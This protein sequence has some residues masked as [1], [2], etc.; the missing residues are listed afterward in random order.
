MIPIQWL[1]EALHPSTSK[2][3]YLFMLK[4]YLDE[5]GHSSDSECRFVGMGGLVAPSENWEVFTVAWQSALD[6]FIEG[7]PFH[8]KEYV[9]W[10][11]AVGPYV[12]FT[13]LK[14]RA[15]MARLIKAIVDCDARMVGC[16][17]SIDG[18]NALIPQHQKM[19]R[20]PYFMAF[21]DAT[22]GCSICGLSLDG[23][24]AGEHVAMV[25]AYQEEFGAIESGRTEAVQQGKAEQLWHAI[26]AQ[27]TITSQW[28]G[29]YSSALADDVCA[30]QAADLFAYEITHEFENRLKR[31]HLDMRW[32]LRQLLAKE[33]RQALIKFVSFEAMLERLMDGGYIQDDVNIRLA[34]TMVQLESKM[35][36]S[37][38]WSK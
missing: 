8:M 2:R 22:H 26:K 33:Q 4:A 31:P 7:K 37:G 1:A 12:G 17:V 29:V 16:V 28:M 19:F 11:D 24:N 5:S 13:E 20:D 21:Q 10:P 38:R 14:R 27:Q 32:G 35:D 25:Y 23:P 30:L 36:M 9:C 15:F 18:F 34:S 3:R 6:E